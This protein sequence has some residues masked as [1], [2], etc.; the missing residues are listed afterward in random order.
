[1]YTR[2]LQLTLWSKSILPRTVSVANDANGAKCKSS[3]PQFGASHKQSTVDSIDV[4]RLI[5]EKKGYAVTSNN[6]SG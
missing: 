2:Y 4:I 5:N 3:M 6:L 1:M